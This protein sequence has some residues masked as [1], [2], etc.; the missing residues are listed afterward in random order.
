MF[1]STAFPSIPLLNSG[2]SQPAPA[3]SSTPPVVPFDSLVLAAEHAA[4]TTHARN[5]A[6][7]AAYDEI[8]S[9][10]QTEEAREFLAALVFLGTR[11]TCRTAP[12]TREAPCQNLSDSFSIKS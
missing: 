12:D 5:A 11:S 10:L 9:S 7:V 4:E 1:A 6:S 8:A 3:K 2:S